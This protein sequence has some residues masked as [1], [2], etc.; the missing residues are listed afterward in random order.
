MLLT[1]LFASAFAYRFMSQIPGGT[2]V[3]SPNKSATWIANST[4]G[5][6]IVL[7]AG[8]V[9]VMVVPVAPRLA[10]DDKRLTFV[11]CVGE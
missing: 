2:T 4:T 7:L 8:V 5:T 9:N 6:S 1:S 11:F 3:W 10:V